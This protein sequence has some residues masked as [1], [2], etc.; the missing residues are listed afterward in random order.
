MIE[1]GREGLARDEV[2][3]RPIAADRAAPRRA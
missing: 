2:A 1:L 3:V